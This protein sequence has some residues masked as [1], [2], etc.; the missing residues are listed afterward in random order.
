MA[1]PG[2]AATINQLH[3]RKRSARRA[4]LRAR[5]PLQALTQRAY[6]HI[7]IYQGRCA[8]GRCLERYRLLAKHP[9]CSRPSKNRQRQR[10]PGR[11]WPAGIPL[12][13]LCMQPKQLLLPRNTTLLFARCE[14]EA[15]ANVDRRPNTMRRRDSGNQ[16]LR[17]HNGNSEVQLSQDDSP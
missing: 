10:C 15:A 1:H 8:P 4:R 3:P 17:H 6:A 9:L 14:P 12:I 13:G 7:N 11:R 16:K 2:M 5:R